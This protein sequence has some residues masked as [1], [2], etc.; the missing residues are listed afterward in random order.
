MMGVK[1]ILVRVLSIKKIV[2]LIVNFALILAECNQMGEK[3]ADFSAG[4]NGG[5]EVS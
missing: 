2:S 4:L 1:F 3:E 5:F